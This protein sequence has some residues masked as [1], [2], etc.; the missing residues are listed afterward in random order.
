MTEKSLR[1]ICNLTTDRS[2]AG[3]LSARR[4]SICAYNRSLNGYRTTSN[5]ALS[6]LRGSSHPPLRH[7]TLG[8]MFDDVW[9]SS[10][11]TDDVKWYDTKQVSLDGGDRMALISSAQNLRWTWK[12]FREKVDNMAVN[13]L[14]RGYKKGIPTRQSGC[15]T[16][17]IQHRPTHLWLTAIFR[18]SNRHMDA[19]QCRMVG[20]RFRIFQ[21]RCHRRQHEP[22]VQGTRDTVSQNADT[23]TSPAGGRRSLVLI[24]PSDERCNW[25][26][27]E[28]W[29]WRHSSNLVDI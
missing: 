8:Q 14:Q 18:W 21:I 23:C 2:S 15:L 24:H 12:Q 26:T 4:L 19:D 28:V 25:P 17:N 11:V 3:M 22:S 5:V 29:W 27:R 13:M 16:L 10:T 20:V 9:R 6:H 1:T 7:Q